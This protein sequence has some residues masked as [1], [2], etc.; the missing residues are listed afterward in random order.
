M[1]DKSLSTG[2]A[3]AASS[4]CSVQSSSILLLCKAEPSRAEQAGRWLIAHMN[5]VQLF[6]IWAVEYCAEF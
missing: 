6:K 2:I 3:A 5:M 4:T 1:G